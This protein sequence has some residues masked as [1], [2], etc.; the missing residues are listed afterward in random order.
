MASSKRVSRINSLLQ[1]VIS[2]VIHQDLS[3][4]RLE[5]KLLSI[6]KV[7]V[8]KDLRQAK[9]YVSIIGDSSEREFV[10]NI[11]KQKIHFI[12]VTASKKV[13]L[14]FFPTISFIIDTT[15][16]HHMRIDELLKQV[17]SGK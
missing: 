5:N 7:D 12:A 9:V 16:D 15:V 10:L 14:R 2:E 3:D 11:L 6:S 17:K 13:T 4:P 1:E 8:T